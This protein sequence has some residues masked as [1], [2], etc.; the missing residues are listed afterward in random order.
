MDRLLDT[1]D[2]EIFLDVNKPLDN[3]PVDFE[4]VLKLDLY[5][6]DTINFVKSLQEE[7]KI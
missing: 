4:T 3:L 2:V 1:Y 5:F 7:D 6:K